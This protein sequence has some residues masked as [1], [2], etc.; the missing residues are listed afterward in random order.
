M[1]YVALLRGINLGR[2][3]VE[4]SVLRALFSE[5]GL[6]DV[7]T[8]VASGN[9]LFTTRSGDS[10]ALGRRIERQLRTGLGYDVDTFLRTADE[11]TRTAATR[12]FAPGDEASAHGVY[13]LFLRDPL[14]AV[15][16]PKLE[17][18]HTDVDAFHVE[19]REIH[20][21]SRVPMSRSVI[22]KSPAVKA[23]RLPEGTLRNVT[24]VRRIAAMLG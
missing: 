9:V 6:T 12:P 7:A 3:R 17:A 22:W 10:G 14:P 21:L 4:M 5:A 8:V 16:A 24:T 2:R 19:G 18:C 13:V 23:L 1:R 15:V 20:W 11:V